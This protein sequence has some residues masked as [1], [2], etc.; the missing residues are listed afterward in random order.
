MGIRGVPP[1]QSQIFIEAP[2]GA[3]LTLDSAVK[4]IDLAFMELP[5]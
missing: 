4:D 2:T 3:R 1:H 5:I